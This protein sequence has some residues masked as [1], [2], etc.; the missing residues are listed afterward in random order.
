MRI[1]LAVV[2]AGVVAT[3]VD[4]AAA[5]AL[6]GADFLALSAGKPGRFGVA[7]AGAALL[8]LLF[9]R[10]RG[11]AGLAI[12]YLVLTLGAAALAKGVFGYGAPW[13]NV[14]LLTSI[15]AVTAIV[16]YRIVR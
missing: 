4:N 11:L 15:Y 5:A 1:V 8:P 9:A 3:L 14:L 13:P 16:V 6:F 10:F 7:I 12:A 2:V